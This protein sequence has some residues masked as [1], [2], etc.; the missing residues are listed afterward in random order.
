[1]SLRTQARRLRD[2]GLP[3]YDRETFVRVSTDF[4]LNVNF[5]YDEMSFHVTKTRCFRKENAFIALHLILIL[6][7]LLIVS[8]VIF[9]F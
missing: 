6:I 4:P 8:W 9:C 2:D 7:F 3:T 5:I 1:M